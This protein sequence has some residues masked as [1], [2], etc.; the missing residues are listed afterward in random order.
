[1]T[2]WCLRSQDNN[3]KH[4]HFQMWLRIFAAF[5]SPSKASLPFLNMCPKCIKLSFSSNSLINS[6][7]FYLYRQT[8]HNTGTQN[9]PK[10]HLSSKLVPPTHTPTHTHCLHPVRHLWA[11]AAPLIYTLCAFMCLSDVCLLLT[12]CKPQHDIW[13]CASICPC[14]AVCQR[15]GCRDSLSP[16]SSL[17]MC[18]TF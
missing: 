6:I 4:S 5:S 14:F 16:S 8:L 10:V 15:D 3:T 12:R 13:R 11:T 1:M 2:S 7:Q 18:A 9:V 17:A